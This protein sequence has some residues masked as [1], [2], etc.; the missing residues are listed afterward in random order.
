MGSQLFSN[1]FPS[2]APGAYPNIILKVMNADKI[3]PPVWPLFIFSQH[4]MVTIFFIPHSG[5]KH[6]SFHSLL[7]TTLT[8]SEILCV[9]L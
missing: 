1:R 3:V 8:L 6:P 4:F 7:Q 9:N 2:V 5:I